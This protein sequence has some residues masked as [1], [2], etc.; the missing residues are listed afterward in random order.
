ML[1]TACPHLC[2]TPVHRV[3]WPKPASHGKP[4]R[5]VAAAH[6]GRGGWTGC[7]S[8]RPESGQ[9]GPPTC[10][11][12]PAPTELPASDAAPQHRFVP[13]LSWLPSGTVGPPGPREEGRCCGAPIQAQALFEHS[14]DPALGDSP[15]CLAQAHTIVFQPLSLPGPGGLSTLKQLTCPRAWAGLEQT[16]CSESPPAWSSPAT[17]APRSD[18][19]SWQLG[20]LPVPYPRI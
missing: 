11:E 20:P 16:L 19:R 1:A 8:S 3:S 2:A 6:A 14:K 4:S 7:W 9:L 17:A 18:Q 12:E 10:L 15:G 5:T 13:S